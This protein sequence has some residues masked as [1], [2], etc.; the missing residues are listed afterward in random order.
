M[1]C[2]ASL[3]LVLLPAAASFADTPAPARRF[4][5]VVGANRGAADR[6]PLRFAVADAE[7]FAA[8]M[9]R[10]GGVEPADA[11]VLHDPTRRAFLDGLATLRARADRARAESGRVDVLV[12]FSGHADDKALMLGRELLLYRDLRA[13]LGEIPADVGITILD[14]CAS[15]A[16]TRLKG[17]QSHPAF[18][19]DVSSA[20]RGYAFLTSS[21]ENEAAQESER[22]QGSFFTHALL[23]GLRGAADASGDGKVTLGEAYQF[24]FNETLVQTTTTQGGAQHPA[25]DIKIA[26]TGDVVMTDVRQTSSSLLLGPEYDGRF[27]V[28][29]ARGQL[30]A[31]LHKPQGRTVELGVEPGVYEVYFEQA[32]A[33]LAASVRLEEGEHRELARETLKPKRRLP[34][35]VRGPAAEPP[36]DLL[37]G[38]SR[39]QALLIT[40]GSVTSDATGSF[41]EGGGGILSFVHWLKRD[42]AF[43][44]AFSGRDLEVASTANESRVDGLYGAWLGMRFYPRMDGNIRPYAA[45]ALGAFGENVVLSGAGR[46]ETSSTDAKVGGNLGG[47]VDLYLG[48]HFNIAFDGRLTF[49]SGLSSR[50]DVSTG[51]G[52]AWGGRH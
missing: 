7:R 20:V 28:L 15:G 35:H 34:T 6:V 33:L 22:L 45:A 51:L 39:V 29:N 5:L 24:A 18:L 38:R 49:L 4:A 40:G 43:E 8:V 9:T 44:L 27:F 2:L 48:R 10:M 36:R 26:G 41:V 16:I 1:R 46:T 47:G 17:G 50:F 52:W 12:Y 11:L 14:A 30:V 32:Q 31:E 3:A 13:A 37:H 23:T 21:S 19:T 42:L 25:Y